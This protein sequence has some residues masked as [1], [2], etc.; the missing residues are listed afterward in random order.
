MQMAVLSIVRICTNMTN[1]KQYSA[2]DEWVEKNSK[3]DGFLDA[4]LPQKLAVYFTR[5]VWDAATAAERERC[6]NL[7][8]LAVSYAK[9][10][11]WSRV[12]A[13]LGLLQRPNV[14]NNRPPAFGG[15]A[16]MSV[17]RQVN[18][19]KDLECKS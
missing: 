5:N 17:G 4:A 12:D 18:E 2:F 13:V 19:G 7:A 1:K 8:D 6:K 15:S 14:A 11:D 16:G 9:D 10:A 3:T